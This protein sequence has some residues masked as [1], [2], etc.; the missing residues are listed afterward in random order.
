MLLLYIIEVK[1]M[2]R[3]AVKK[4]DKLTDIGVQIRIPRELIP[5]VKAFIQAF[6]DEKQAEYN[7]NAAKTALALASAKAK[8]AKEAQQGL[9]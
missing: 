5:R 4:G 9:C 7:A 3:P 6:K 8:N 2:G 1:N